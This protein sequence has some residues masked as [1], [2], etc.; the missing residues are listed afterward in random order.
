ME[1]CTELPGDVDGDGKADLIIYRRSAGL[2][3]FISENSSSN[4]GLVRRGSLGSACRCRTR[5]VVGDFDGDGRVDEAVFR[6]STGQ[7]LISLSSNNY[8]GTTS[9]TWGRS[10]PGAG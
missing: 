2:G 5:P 6:R 3:Q 1:T 10:G 7:W 8:S 9:C 4:Y